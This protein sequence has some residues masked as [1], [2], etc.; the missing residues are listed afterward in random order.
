MHPHHRELLDLMKPLRDS[1]SRVR[2]NT[3]RFDDAQELQRAIDKFACVLTG[4][5]EY[6]W[7]RPANFQAK[8]PSSG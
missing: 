4:N 6:F 1:L 7:A 5:P 3:P 8:G 2:A